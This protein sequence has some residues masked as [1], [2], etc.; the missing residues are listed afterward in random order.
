LAL[1]FYSLILYLLSPLIVLRLL[2]RSIKAPAYR[3]RWRERFGFVP[4]VKGG[5]PVIWVHAVSVGETLAAIPLIR[6]LQADNPASQLLVTT[7]TPTGSERVTATFGN[8][9]IH[10]YAPYDLPDAV[11]R[12]LARTRPSRLVIMETELWPVLIDEC[13]KQ[14]IPVIVANARLSEK[15]ARGYGKFPA[16]TAPM[17]EKITCVAAQHEDDGERFVALGLPGSQLAV[18]GNIKFDLDITEA[19]REKSQ[20]LSR[21]WR[22]S[23]NRPVWLVASTHKGE[24]EIILQSFAL[25]KKQIPEVLLVLVPRHPERFDS[26]VQLCQQKGWVVARRSLGQ[27]PDAN[28]AILVGDTMGELAVFFGACDIAFVGGSLV[29]VGGHN[30]IE[31]AA[32]G[33]ATITGPH[34]FNFAEVSRLLIDADALEVVE[35]PQGLAEAVVALLSDRPRC[36]AQGQAALEVALANRGAMGRLLALIEQG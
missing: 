31:P 33:V 23:D 20:Q 11:K 13:R 8:S 22:G 16:L 25:I 2:W 27:R 32:W 6:R 1:F 9:V 12:F 18:T 15:S 34:L 14:G 21:E 17:L 7:M 35:D 3:R 10:V 19:Q 24:D 28:T 5:A 30:L 29:P 26:V 36:T 4:F